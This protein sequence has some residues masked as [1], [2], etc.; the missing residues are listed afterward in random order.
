MTKATVESI[1]FHCK[2]KSPLSTRVMFVTL[3]FG[4]AAVEKSNFCRTFFPDAIWK[5]T[6][7]VS[8]EKRKHVVLDLVLMRN[9]LS[10][11]ELIAFLIVE[12]NVENLI[13]ISESSPEKWFERGKHESLQ[14][15][16]AKLKS[17]EERIDTM[18][19]FERENRCTVIK[20]TLRLKEQESTRRIS[21]IEGCDSGEIETIVI[22]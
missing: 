19:Y 16:I 10:Y 9:V 3:L 12:Q 7:A 21:A 8:C 20:G 1:F 5:K 2:Q 18:L 15:Y 13:L 11:S 6:L 22:E 17:I 14:A 4:N